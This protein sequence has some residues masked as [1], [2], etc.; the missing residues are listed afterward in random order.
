M[1]IFGKGGKPRTPY[2]VASGDRTQA[3]LLVGGEY[4]HHF[5]IK[6]AKQLH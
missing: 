4:S 2:G 3:T 1:L 6:I 5:E